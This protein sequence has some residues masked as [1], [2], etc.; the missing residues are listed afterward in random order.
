MAPR[1]TSGTVAAAVAALALAAGAAAGAAGAVG[2]EFPCDVR[3]KGRRR[4]DPECTTTVW[5]V[6]RAEARALG[7]KRRTVFRSCPS[8]RAQRRARRGKTQLAAGNLPGGDDKVLAGFE[9]SSV[10]KSG[11]LWSAVTYDDAGAPTMALIRDAEST[12]V[13]AEGAPVEVA[14]SGRRRR[15]GMT[16][17]TRTDEATAPGTDIELFLEDHPLPGDHDL[18]RA[19]FEAGA[20][21]AAACSAESTPSAKV[22]YELDSEFVA[23]KGGVSAAVA[24]ATDLT[25]IATAQYMLQAGVELDTEIFIDTNQSPTGHSYTATGALT[26]L[27]EFT[28]R[29]NADSSLQAVAADAAVVHLISGR[30][31]PEDPTVLGIAWVAS[32][33]KTS[34]AVAISWST[35]LDNSPDACKIALIMHENGHTFSL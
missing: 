16:C 23:E 17:R 28:A 19:R 29:W 2:A 8:K 14:Q 15:T 31:P 7:L 9:E 30:A 10:T 24:E 34:K 26:T 11:F 18:G 21:V 33:C 32:A 3:V 25:N 4:G 1:N 12:L 13:F 22:I 20:A 35:R 5:R 6:P 27:F